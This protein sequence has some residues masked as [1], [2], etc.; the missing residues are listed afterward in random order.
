VLADNFPL[1]PTLG[2]GWHFDLPHGT[3]EVRL[4]SRIWVPAQMHPDEAD[5]RHLGVAVGNL[6]LDGREVSLASPALVG[7]WHAPEQSG[8]WTDGDGVLAVAGARPLAFKLTM[9][10]TYRREP[11]PMRLN[12][13]SA[14]A[15]PSGDRAPGTP[16]K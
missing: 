12:L 5:P 4:A 8:R 9:T 3:R 2:S 13:R 16:A 7:G 1:C 6:W 14:R 15:R 10:G 11:A